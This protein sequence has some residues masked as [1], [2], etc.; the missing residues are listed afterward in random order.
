[1]DCGEALR[2]QDHA[3]AVS[4][5]LA[6][7]EGLLGPGS[8]VSQTHP[9]FR[10]DL[11][12]FRSPLSRNRGARTALAESLNARRPNAPFG[13]NRGRSTVVL[14]VSDSQTS[15][16][17]P[18]LWG[19]PL[20]W[21][22]AGDDPRTRQVMQPLPRWTPVTLAVVKSRKRRRR[23]FQ[24][25]AV[26]DPERFSRCGMSYGPRSRLSSLAEQ[27]Y[28]VAGGGRVHDGYLLRISDA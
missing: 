14:G 6:F 2:S 25:D 10:G 4:L 22:A 7:K 3:Q 12:Q 9:R 24:S 20:S 8:L 15:S 1:V 17:M 19:C 5:R 18:R 23:F 26:V 21:G 11:P 28:G 27:Q 13:R 16:A